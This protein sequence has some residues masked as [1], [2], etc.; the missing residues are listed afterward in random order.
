MQIHKVLRRRIR[1]AIDGVDYSGDVNAAIAA[2]VGERSQTTSVHS[3][4]TA[5][6]SSTQVT[7]GKTTPPQEGADDGRGANE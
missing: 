1:A 3:R 5:D 6:A 7:T 2:N 4:S